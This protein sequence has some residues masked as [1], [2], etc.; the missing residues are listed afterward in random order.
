VVIAAIQNSRLSIIDELGPP[1]LHPPD[2]NI[3]IHNLRDEIAEEETRTEVETGDELYRPSNITA[4]KPII[5]TDRQLGP[6]HAR[7]CSLTKR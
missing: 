6:N 7:S 2:L 5:P 3:D 1:L 4:S